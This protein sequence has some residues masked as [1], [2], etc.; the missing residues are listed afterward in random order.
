MDHYPP[1]ILSR[2]GLSWTAVHGLVTVIAIPSFHPQPVPRPRLRREEPRIRR[3]VLDLVPQPVH[4]LLEELPVAAAAP[5]P[6][7]RE[8]PFGGDHVARV[9]QQDLHQPHLELGEAQRLAFVDAQCVR[10]EVEAQAPGGQLLSIAANGQVDVWRA[11][12]SPAARDGAPL[13][14]ANAPDL[15]L[16]GIAFAGNVTAGEPL[17]GVLA[18]GNQAGTLRLW[19]L[20]SRTLIT[21]PKTG[22]TLGNLSLASAPDGNFFIAIFEMCALAAQRHERVDF[23]NAQSAIVA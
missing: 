16:T 14:R 22:H 10:L 8:Q 1:I 5:P 3:V 20:G 12:V 13:L 21:L 18:L 19:D 23:D 4:E 2:R 9:R 17:S 11:A 15:P 6:D 7:V